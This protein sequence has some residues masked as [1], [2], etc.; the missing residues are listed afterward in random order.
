LQTSPRNIFVSRLDASGA[1]LGYSTYF[2]GGP[3]EIPYGIA[4]S[5]GSVYLTGVTEADFPTT[6]LAFDHTFNNVFDAFVTK[7]D[8]DRPRLDHFKLYD[9]DAGTGTRPVPVSLRDQFGALHR[10]VGAPK[11]F[12]VP[13]EK[14]HNGIVTPVLQPEALLVANELEPRK[15]PPRSV[16]VTNQFGSEVLDV[17]SAQLLLVP[18]A[19]RRKAIP[20]RLDHFLC[21]QATS[22]EGR[23]RPTVSLSDGLGTDTWQLGG[24]FLLCNPVEKT[25]RGRLTPIGSPEEHLT[26]Y[27]LPDAEP[28]RAPA[29]NVWNQFG[30]ARLSIRGPRA[31]CVPSEK[32]VLP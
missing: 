30:P 20:D 23:D 9:V 4:W 8:M 27:E 5:R 14:T 29:T 1:T 19:Q 25:H 3:Q 12:G 31:L 7:L 21:Y 16:E 26:C 2:G 18:S 28:T 10:L 22:P 6:A 24:P 11:L 17:G 32:R 15:T 13:V